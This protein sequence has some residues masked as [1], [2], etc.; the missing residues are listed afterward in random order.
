MRL[1]AALAAA[2]LVAAAALL[3]ATPPAPAQQ[4]IQP[5]QG[6][7]G[8]LRADSIRYDAKNKVLEAKG[9]VTLVIEDTTITSSVLVYHE[10]TKVAWAEG[11]ARVVQGKTTLTAPS[12]KYEVTPQVTHATGGVVVTQPDVDLRAQELTYQSKEQIVLAEKDVTLTT[13]G[14][15]ITGPTLWANLAEKRA[16]V[17]G[18]ARMVRKGGRP[19]RGRENDRVLAALAKEDTTITAQRFL[20]FSWAQTDEAEAAGDV[21]VDQVDKKAR[22]DSA[23]YSE[24][25]DRIE[26]VGNARIDQVSGQWLIREK[27][28]DTPRTEEERQALESPAVLT[29]DRV[30]ITLSTRNSV[31]TGNVKVTQVGRTAT[32]DRSEYD[33]V[34]GKI[35][36]TGKRARVERQDGSWLEART[37]VVS[38]KED[39]FEAFGDVDTTFTVNR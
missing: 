4:G 19:P 10:R 7:Q 35:V 23:V 25:K 33:D 22:G 28:A 24:A 27:L 26:I 20:K 30:V 31:A 14:S 32:G 36:L 37:V 39:T 2:A 8:R 38:L 21:A 18:R 29:A 15:K 17:K 9:N 3:V 16:E 11:D 1:A 5:P 34:A 12:I 13:E 6:G